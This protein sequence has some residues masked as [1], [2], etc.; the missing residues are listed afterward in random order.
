MKWIS[1]KTLDRKQFRGIPDAKER[2]MTQHDT[3]IATLQKLGY[4]IVK[5]LK[6]CT[7]MSSAKPGM[8]YYAGSH[9]SVRR[10][11]NRANS[12]PCSALPA[13][14]Q[15]LTAGDQS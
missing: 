4:T 9:G 3:N 8:F 5:K 10:G 12:I 2:T 13:V 1:N 6:G 14:L 7:V 11:T 15:R